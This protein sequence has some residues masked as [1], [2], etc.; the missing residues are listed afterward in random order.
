MLGVSEWLALGAAAVFAALGGTVLVQRAQINDARADLFEVRSELATCGGRLANILEDV[1]S[2]N[3][4]DTLPDDALRSV[5][6]HWLRPERA[7]N[8]P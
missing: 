1:E 8:D 2:D 3:A 5:P 4:I 7:G 6:D